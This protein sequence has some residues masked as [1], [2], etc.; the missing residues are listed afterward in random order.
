MKLDRPVTGPVLLSLPLTHGR[1]LIV[2][3]ESKKFPPC[4]GPSNPPANYTPM[5][6]WRGYFKERD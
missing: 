3:W 6:F 4:G 2:W 1:Q 5:S